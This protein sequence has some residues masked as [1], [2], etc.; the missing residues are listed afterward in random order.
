MSETD[1]TVESGNFQEITASVGNM[2]TLVTETAKQALNSSATNEETLPI[3]SRIENVIDDIN[4]VSTT[5]TKNI[6]RFT[7][8]S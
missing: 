1:T 4:Q 7:I 2:N 5:I 3:V 8:R 6:G